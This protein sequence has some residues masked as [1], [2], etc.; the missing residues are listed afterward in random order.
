MTSDK[1]Q[2]VEKTLFTCWS[3]MISKRRKD[4]LR[5]WALEACGD[6]PTV[7]A[8]SLV[9]SEEN[10]LIETLV[11]PPGETPIGRMKNV[12]RKA[13]DPRAPDQPG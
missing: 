7:E 13:A 9:L 3:R 5:H 1:L 10:S 6:H 8:M 2:A 12:G 4:V 11:L